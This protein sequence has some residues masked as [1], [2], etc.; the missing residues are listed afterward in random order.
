MK[1][2]ERREKLLEE[3]KEGNI[4]HGMSQMKKS[5]PIRVRRK[6]ELIE[7]S[8]DPEPKSQLHHLMD[9]RSFSMSSISP[10]SRPLS[11]GSF[12]S[13]LEERARKLILGH[14]VKS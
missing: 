5:E 2:V 3:Y 8:K 10:D 1:A 12:R 13:V 11:H 14:P 9:S 7:E 4:K 6:Q